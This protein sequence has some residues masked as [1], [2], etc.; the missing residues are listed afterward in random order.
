MKPL[1]YPDRHFALAAEGWL[2]LD[3]P[4]EAERE[5]GLLS[6]VALRHPTVLAVRWR[7]L[8]RNREWEQALEVAQD[9]TRLAPDRMESWVNQSYALHE[10]RRTAEA[11]SA[12]LKIAGKFP[13]ESVIPYNLACYDCQLGNLEQA[14]DWLRKAV[15]LRSRDEIRSDALKD[16]DLA[17]LRDFVKSL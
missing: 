13:E 1:E 5:L 3:N 8:A 2:E 16:P 15:R 6:P 7:L 12:L 10:L 9:M 14:Q 11:K 17:P 4:A